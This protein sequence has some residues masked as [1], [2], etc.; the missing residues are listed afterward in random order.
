MRTQTDPFFAT[1]SAA[2]YRQCFQLD[3][4]ESNR[5]NYS[6][7]IASGSRA[8]GSR[9]AALERVR[10]SEGRICANDARQ[11]TCN[12]APPAPAR[13]QAHAATRS[14][15]LAV[16]GRRRRNTAGRR[17]HCP[18]RPTRP[19]AP[20]RGGHCSMH[21]G[22]HRRTERCIRGRDRGQP[23]EQQA[24]RA[25]DVSPRAATQQRHEPEQRGDDQRRAPL[26]PPFRPVLDQGASV[27]L[28]GVG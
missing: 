15:D 26:L 9:A 7:A 4:Q 2:Y 17:A 6:A 8:A 25:C 28:G 12:A 23:G 5:E 21:I 18:T 27:A 14:A 22:Y 20:G 16:A 19:T 1:C 10:V 13:S 11:S 24:L 3:S